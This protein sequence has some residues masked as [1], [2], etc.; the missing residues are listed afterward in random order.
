[1]RAS[2]EFG[3]SQCH[4]V[5]IIESRIYEWTRRRPSSL[6]VPLGAPS[7]GSTCPTD[8]QMSLKRNRQL[9]GPEYARR[10]MPSRLGRDMLQAAGLMVRGRTRLTE[11]CR[12]TSYAAMG[13]VAAA[14]SKARINAETF[15][16]SPAF[17]RKLVLYRRAR[18]YDLR[19]RNVRGRTGEDIRT[20]Q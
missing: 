14:S 11:A 20:I 16:G 6:L 15:L 19:T 8:Q 17:I 4:V 1:M 5:S 10:A 7:I 9:K 3:L 13:S 18:K 12:W 2:H